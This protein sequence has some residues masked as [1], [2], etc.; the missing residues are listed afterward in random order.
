[1]RHYPFELI[2]VFGTDES[3]SRFKRATYLH[4]KYFLTSKG[5]SKP[6]AAH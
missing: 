2:V 6:F 3:V 5:L 1:M 4:H